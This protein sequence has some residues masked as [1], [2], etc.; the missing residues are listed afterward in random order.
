MI[1]ITDHLIEKLREPCRSRKIGDQ[2]LIANHL[3]KDGIYDQ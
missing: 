3:N 2:E 1:F